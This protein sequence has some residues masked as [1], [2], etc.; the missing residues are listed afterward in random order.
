MQILLSVIENF[1][2]EHLNLSKNANS[3]N[4]ENNL[5]RRGLT[6]IVKDNNQLHKAEFVYFLGKFLSENQKI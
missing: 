1:N 3:E 5:G 2:I 6:N 4:K